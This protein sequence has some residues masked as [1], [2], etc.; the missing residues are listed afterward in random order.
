LEQLAILTSGKRKGSTAGKKGVQRLTKSSKIIKTIIAA[1]EEKKGEH[2]VSL[3]LRKITEAVADFFIICEAKSQPQVRAI[4]DHVAEM[5]HQKCDERPFRQ[6]G[7]QQLQW[8]L[9]DYVNVVVH[10]MLP[11]NRKFY[12]LEEM[13]SDAVLAEFG[14]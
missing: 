6:E 1:I 12:K 13:W 7:Q 3:D 9:I 2:I 5:V 4:A 10:V 11:E 14:E 8:V